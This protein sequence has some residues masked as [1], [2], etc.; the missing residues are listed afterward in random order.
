MESL[1]PVKSKEIHRTESSNFTTPEHLSSTIPSISLNCPMP[2]A[3][4]PEPLRFRQETSRAAIIFAVSLVGLFGLLF[5]LG[6]ITD[7][8]YL[9]AGDWG[10][11]FIGLVLLG[12]D[13]LMYRYLTAPGIIL[14]GDALQ[15]NRFFRDQIIPYAEMAELSSYLE[16]IHPPLINGTR[17]P[18]RIIHRLIV[19]PRDAEEIRMILPSFGSNVSVI[20]A[21]E[22]RSGLHVARLPDVDKGR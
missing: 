5:L 15:V 14:T 11:G 13:I 16:R 9:K 21:L 17:M 10:T 4:T 1:T 20:E 7:L 8:S 12:L 18:P 3:P 6:F 2:A 22:K 19:K